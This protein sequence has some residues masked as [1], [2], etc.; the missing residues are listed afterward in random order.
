MYLRESDMN[1]EAAV[2]YERLV[3]DLS[4]RCADIAGRG[5]KGEVALF[6]R[7]STARIS[8]FR[9]PKRCSL[10]NLCLSRAV[11]HREVQ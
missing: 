4:G 1:R 11:G 8:F 5:P 10:R 9:K 7:M 2:E 6:V 3:G